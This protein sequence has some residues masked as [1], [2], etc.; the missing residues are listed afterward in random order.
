[1]P[2]VLHHQRMDPG[3]IVEAR[4]REV[5]ATLGLHDF[6][7]TVPVVAT[8]KGTD[9]VG[10]GLLI[11]NGTGA[12]LQVKS[13]APDAQTGKAKSWVRKHA[14]K[15]FRQAIGSL[16]MIT[17]RQSEGEPLRAYPERVLH[18][19]PE[20]Q[21]LAALTLDHDTSTWPMIVVIDHPEADG[22]PVPNDEA[23]FVTLHDWRELNSAIRS[24]TGLIEYARRVIDSP[25]G[26][27]L[28]GDE[29]QRFAAIVEADARL[30][31]G[32]T[33]GWFNFDALDDADGAQCYRE[34]LDRLWP[35]DQPVPDVGVENYR[36]IVEHLDAVPPGIQVTLGRRMLDVRRRLDEH[37][38]WQS[39]VSVVNHE[40][41]LVLAAD[42]LSNH[43]GGVGEFDSE[44]AL[45]SAVRG[46]EV[47]EQAGATVPVLGV[48][49]LLDDDGI[50]YRY[51]FQDP[52]ADVPEGL[53]RA[54]ELRRGR[55]DLAARGIVEVD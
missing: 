34:L 6:V 31:H 26:P 55:L 12:V 17:R 46:H 50:F 28:L 2:A 40:H 19:P 15:G 37:G 23:L 45:L 53:R 22:L 9:E 29:F 24:T 41:V 14:T 49:H 39:S 18:L 20:E 30:D 38:T 48:G 35:L 11:A 36:R 42:R 8:A 43:P 32:G 4:V 16:K 27:P 5:A 21:E 47:A 10:D 33:H 7:Y 44:L 25:I 1:V 51:L 52:P 3:R 13:R 54:T